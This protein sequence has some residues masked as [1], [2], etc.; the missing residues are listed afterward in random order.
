LTSR[1][2]IVRPLSIGLFVYV[3]MLIAAP[4]LADGFVTPSVGANFGG[5]AG[6]CA[7]ATGCSSKH[8]TYGVAL[9]YMSGGILGVEEEV[10]YAPNFF[11]RVPT[12][13]NNSVLT[14]MT[15]IMI[16]APLGPIRPY[17]SGGIG[18]IRLNANLAPGGILTVNNT[19]LG[20]DLG[21]GV[22]GFFTSHIGLQADYHYIRNTQNV[23]LGGFSI[24]NTQLTFSRGTL[25]VVLRF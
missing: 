21:G 25:G 19:S 23:T 9:G 15:N 12:F 8:L 17:V 4:A 24:T 18:I 7:S 14:A 3:G 22:M 5:D 13:G 20:Y 11:G 16:G 6:S 10:S 1:I 2:M